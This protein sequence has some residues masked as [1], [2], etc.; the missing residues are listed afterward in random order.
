MSRGKSCGCR[1]GN[2]KAAA[3]RD[4]M[5]ALMKESVYSSGAGLC[6]APHQQ[7]LALARIEQLERP[8]LRAAA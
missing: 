5:G 4:S 1:P 6:L 3:L 8:S 7:I 2:S